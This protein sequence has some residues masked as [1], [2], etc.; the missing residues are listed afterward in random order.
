MAWVEQ[1]DVWVICDSEDFREGLV[2]VDC[3]LYGVRDSS[4]FVTLRMAG[5][6]VL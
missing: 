2:E 1:I 5:Q 4:I 3:P 6:D